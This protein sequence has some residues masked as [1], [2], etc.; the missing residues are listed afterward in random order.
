MVVYELKCTVTGKS[1]I[2]KTQLYLKERTRQHNAQ[3]WKVIE[4][5]RAK[6]GHDKWRGSGGFAAAD[7]YAKHFAQLCRDLP[8]KNEVNAK[9]KEIMVP[10]ILWQGDRIQCMKSAKTWNCKI[11]MVERMEILHRMRTDK[12]KIMNDNS[13]IFAACK[14]GAR[15]HK[16]TNRIDLP[17]LRTRL[18]QKKVSSTRHSKQRRL[19]SRFSFNLNSTRASRRTSNPPVTPEQESPPETP[20]LL[21]DTNIPGLPRRP[22]RR[23]SEVTNL[24]IAQMRSYEAMQETV[25]C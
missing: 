5:G 1:Y 14:C 9:L 15:F 13:D 12:D 17:T 10:S 23:F 25:D 2:G 8:T 7:A 16:F 22:L 19:S 3:V 6:Y 4:S 24:E 11:C 21:L 18:T 20:V